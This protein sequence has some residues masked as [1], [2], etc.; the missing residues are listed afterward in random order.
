MCTYRS[1]CAWVCMGRA[2]WHRALLPLGIRGGSVEQV[3]FE[4]GL[5]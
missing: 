3:A 4:L 5:G 2:V 1:E